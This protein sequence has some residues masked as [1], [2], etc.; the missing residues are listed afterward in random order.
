MGAEDLSP[1]RLEKAKDYISDM[2]DIFDGEHVGLVVFTSTPSVKCVLTLDYTYFMRFLLMKVRLE[3]PNTTYY[4]K[5][6]YNVD[7]IMNCLQQ[8]FNEATINFGI[9]A[10]SI[11]LGSRVLG[12]SNLTFISKNLK[13]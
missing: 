12:N 13:K 9:N 10:V 4:E 1:N 8:Y 6:K 11:E 5:A 3:F 2:I 7:I